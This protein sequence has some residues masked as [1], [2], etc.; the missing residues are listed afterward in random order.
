[1]VNV[2]CEYCSFRNEDHIENTLPAIGNNSQSSLL[3]AA[4]NQ[5]N[6]M[7]DEM[8]RS[9]MLFCCCC[10]VCCVVC[11]ECV[12]VVFLKMD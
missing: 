7:V 3:F 10:F 9:E 12:V 8:V 1:M 11:D 4:I 6:Q 5:S 2:I